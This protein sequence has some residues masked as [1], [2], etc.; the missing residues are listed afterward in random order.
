MKKKF[1]EGVTVGLPYHRATPIEFFF[2][3]LNSII[4]QTYPITHIHIIIDG[5]IKE[6]HLHQIIDKKKKHNNISII[7]IKKQ[8]GLPH[9][10][11]C[12]IKRTKTTFY[13]RMDS[14]DIS[15][16][17]RIMKQVNYLNH[18]PSVMAVGTWAK[19]FTNKTSDSLDTIKT[20]TRFIDI[21]KATHYRSPMVHPT[22]LFRTCIF[23]NVGLYNEKYLRAQDLELWG[24]FLNKNIKIANIAEPLLYLRSNNVLSRRASIDAI[25]YQMLARLTYKTKSPVLFTLKLAS[26]FFRLL[27]QSAQRKMYKIRDSI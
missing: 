27:P 3:A 21:K 19:T 18:H 26:V 7:K 25:R 20:P 6:K 23:Y 1:N 15:H 5:P 16:P 2:E 4:N 10:I 9:A 13:A 11:N 22:V 24:R 14:D 8:H 17:E 12:S